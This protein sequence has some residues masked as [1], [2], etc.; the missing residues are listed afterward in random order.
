M[1]R[2]EGGRLADIDGGGA[3]GVTQFGQSSSP[4]ANSQDGAPAAQL[5][6]VAMG[7]QGQVLAQYDNGQQVVVAQLA[8]AGIRNPETL[9]AVGNNNYQ[10][11]AGTAAPAIGAPETGGRG[12]IQGG[13]LEFSNVDIAREFT[14]LIVLQRGYQANAKVV[15]TVD[16]MS[17]DTISLKQ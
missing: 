15:T 7:N 8:L 17:Q 4:S 3:G 9:V 2:D 6:R 16:Q 5:T 13:S 14:N 11:S 10:L 1:L 12:T